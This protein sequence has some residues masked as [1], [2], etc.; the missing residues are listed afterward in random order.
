[1]ESYEAVI[2]CIYW[3]RG[4]FWALMNMHGVHGDGRYIRSMQAALDRRGWGP[5]IVVP[6]KRQKRERKK[7]RSFDR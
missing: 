2:G 6:V 3:D 1:M 5:F 7:Y 4:V